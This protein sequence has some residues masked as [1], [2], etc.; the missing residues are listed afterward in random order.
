MLLKKFKDPDLTNEVLAVDMAIEGTK[1]HGTVPP[2]FFLYN[3]AG[4]DKL[5]DRAQWNDPDLPGTFGDYLKE[6]IEREYW[7]EDQIKPTPENPPQVLMLVANNPLRRQRSARRTYVEELFPKLKMVFAIEPKM[8]A[9]AAFCDIVLPAA[10]YYEKHDMTMTFGLNP[11][12]ALIERAVEPPGEAK[13]EWEIFARLITR[14]SERASERGMT[15]FTDRTDTE[16]RY[17]DLAKRFTMN[18]HLA[19]QKDALKEMVKVASAIGTFPEAFSY[20]QLREQ[21][22]VRVHGI[23][24]LGGIAAAAEVDPTRPFYSLARHVDGKDIYPTYAR[25]A[26][27]YIEHEWFLAAGE[28]LPVHKDTPPIG[29]QHPFRVVSGHVRGSIHSMHAGTPEFLRLHRGQPI[30]FINDRIAHE[31]GIRDADMV[32]MFNDYDEAEFMAC[33]SASV[34]PDQVLVYMF[35]SWQFKDWKS[36]DAMLIGMPKSLQL[37]GKYGQLNYR[38][39]QGSPSPAN[40][41]GLRVDIE[42]AQVSAVTGSERTG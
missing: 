19:T 16:R 38:Q 3:H 40:D 7:D 41:R 14:I 20:E 27:F 15:S 1:R 39:M 31:R 17:Q 2:V 33:T 13:P 29:G 11:Y 23:G 6:A 37:A 32:R 12:T 18:G 30:L 35:E 25:R 42:L 5:W 10:W 4:Y 9:S 34:G 24:P 22:Q 28:A 36:H 8:S 26:Q 21:G